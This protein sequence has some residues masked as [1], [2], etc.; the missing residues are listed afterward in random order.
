MS[1]SQQCVDCVDETRTPN[2][3]SAQ[4]GTQIST[5]ESGLER[6]VEKVHDPLDVSTFKAPVPLPV[7]SVTIE[8]CDRVSVFHLTYFWSSLKL[9]EMTVP[10]V[11]SQPHK[12]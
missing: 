4:A 5:G 2:P 10:M 12:C 6:D 8:F 1:E 9:T 7:N 3:A 11:C